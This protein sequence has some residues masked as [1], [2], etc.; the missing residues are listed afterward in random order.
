MASEWHDDG[1]RLAIEFAREGDHGELATALCAGAD[2]QTVWW[3]ML[4]ATD[5]AQARELLRQREEID[6]EHPEWVGDTETDPRGPV[7]ETISAW[8]RAKGLDAVV[9]TAL[10]PRCDGIDGRMPSEDDAVRYLDALEGEERAHAEQYVRRVP[11][12]IATR[13]RAAIERA[14]GW[15]PA[16]F[17]S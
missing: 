3:A 8:A 15:T 14:L 13:N 12:V 10:P 5:L 16:P 1:P 7:C 11:A 17:D 4:S 6:P 9:W 2:H